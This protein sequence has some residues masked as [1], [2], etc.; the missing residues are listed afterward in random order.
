MSKESE[1]ERCNKDGRSEKEC[2]G[3]VTERSADSRQYVLFGRIIGVRVQ[4]KTPSMQSYAG[5]PTAAGN[6]GRPTKV[7]F[8]Y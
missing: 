8:I 3:G 4:V 1:T 6:L 5:C 7:I 2:R